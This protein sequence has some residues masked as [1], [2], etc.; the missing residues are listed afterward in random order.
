V[1]NP[2]TERSNVLERDGG[3]NRITHT[4]KQDKESRARP[5]T[6][7]SISIYVGLLLI[8]AIVILPVIYLLPSR[9]SGESGSGNV[10]EHIRSMEVQDL[11]S[12]LTSRN[13]LAVAY[14]VQETGNRHLTSATT[15]L[16]KQLNNNGRLRFPGAEKSTSITQLS[17]IALG[18]IVSN[19]IERNPG[20][21]AIL[22]PL[23]EAARIGTLSERVG[24]IGVLGRIREPLAI[25]LI[26][27]IADRGDGRL[28]ESAT[29]AVAEFRQPQK[30]D[31][32]AAVLCRSETTYLAGLCIIIAVALGTT[33]NRIRL[34]APAK[35]VLL[36]CI[37]AIL[38]VWITLLAGIDFS[39][40]VAVD[41]TIDEA[42]REE[43]LMSLK[44][45]LYDDPVPY[46]GDSYVARHLVK[47]G[48]DRVV[49]C[50][51]QLP[52]AGPDDDG[53]YGEFL[54]KR[55]DWIL[56]RVVSTRLGNRTLDELLD[57]NLTGVRAALAISLGKLGVKNGVVLGALERLSLDPDEGVRKNATKALTLAKKKP[58]WS[59]WE[60]DSQTK[61]QSAAPPTG[62]KGVAPSRR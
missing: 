6:A 1:Q 11:E 45:M 36:L 32:V 13:T 28:Q 56:S 21:I 44:A 26:S 30:N 58:T 33:F 20:D 61:N 3:K 39:M 47:D 40:S 46:P 43:K 10:P 8:L 12:L 23:F 18:S 50:M 62:A 48:S 42:V 15:Q 19:Q 31:W 7:E 53:T 34:R 5:K 59:W 16:I 9:T 54:A 4:R 25:P 14:A 22:R 17:E 51:A 37:P 41:D 2:G 49:S 60:A 27:E 57:S 55:I 29:Q 24:A 38:V 52:S 35:S